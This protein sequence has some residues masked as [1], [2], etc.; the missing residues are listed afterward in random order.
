ML[1]YIFLPLDNISNSKKRIASAVTIAQDFAAHIVGL[2]LLPTLQHIV[3][4]LPQNNRVTLFCGI[5]SKTAYYG[6]N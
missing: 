1:K 3:Q 4:G 6:R 5:Q 2:Q